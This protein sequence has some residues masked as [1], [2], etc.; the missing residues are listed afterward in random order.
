MESMSIYSCCK[1]FR[2]MALSHPEISINGIDFIEVLDDPALPGD[3]SRRI[4]RVHFFKPI[5]NDSLSP[6]NIR[7][8]GGERIKDVAVVDALVPAADGKVLRLVLNRPGDRSTYRLNIVKDRD[9]EDH[10]DARPDGFD[11]ILSEV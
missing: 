11:T 2:R 8:D 5:A 1:D 9:D 3:R 10:P 6:K 4:L 7:I